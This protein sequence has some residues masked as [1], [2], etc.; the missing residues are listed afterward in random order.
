MVAST[1]TLEAMQAVAPSAGHLPDPELV[2][3]VDNLPVTTA[4]RYSFTRDFMTMRKIGVIQSFP[5]GE[6][7]RLL[8][9]LAQRE[10]AVAQGDVRKTRFDTAR[11]V[12]EAWIARAVAEESLVR[13]RTLKA[14][15]QLE[16]AVGRAALAS[17]RVSAAE[18]L[19][20]QRCV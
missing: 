3:G 7:R 2:T 4:E 16:A 12:A 14:D 13:L 11:T 8:G 9:E 1:A 20:A 6:K 10:I 19:A 5:S 17:G 18:A 15:A